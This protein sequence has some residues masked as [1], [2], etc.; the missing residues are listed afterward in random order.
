MALL[1]RKRFD[2][3]R[4]VAGAILILLFASLA[5][6]PIVNLWYVT[7]IVPFLCLTISPA[8][9]ALTA[10][11][12]VSYAGFIESREILW[13]TVV[14][15]GVVLGLFILSRRGDGRNRGI[16]PGIPTDCPTL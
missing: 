1:A 13:L 5:L 4:R 8:L 3:T 10:L 7:W 12:I 16:D 14:E 6:S 15:W 2:S 11:V 9:L